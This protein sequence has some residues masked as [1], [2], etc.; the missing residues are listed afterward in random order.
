MAKFYSQCRSFSYFLLLLIGVVVGVTF[1]LLLYYVNH[2]V[3]CSLYKHLCLDESLEDS[4]AHIC[5]NYH[6]GN[7]LDM[8][9]LVVWLAH[10]CH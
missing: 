1:R 4:Q 8:V 6:D 10:I 9:V 7:L 5:H 2:Y 3:L